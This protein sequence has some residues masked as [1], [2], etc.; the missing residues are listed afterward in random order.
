MTPEKVFANDQY[1]ELL[2]GKLKANTS[3]LR[4]LDVRIK[5]LIPFK[6]LKAIEI[7]WKE[8]TFERAITLSDTSEIERLLAKAYERKMSFLKEGKSIIKKHWVIPSTQL[9]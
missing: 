9:G 4:V 1:T 6:W 5:L 3:R 2:Q 7:M 8:T